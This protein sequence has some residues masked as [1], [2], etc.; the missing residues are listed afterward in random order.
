M[1]KDTAFP[2]PY[3]VYKSKYRS[4]VGQHV[5]VV[6]EKR[7]DFKCSMCNYAAGVRKVLSQHVKSV[8]EHIKDHVCEKCDYKS[9]DRANILRHM[10]RV[11][12]NIREHECSKCDMTFSRSQDL[13][14]HIKTHDRVKKTVS[15]NTPESIPDKRGHITETI[16][17]I[18]GFKSS[19]VSELARHVMEQCAATE[20]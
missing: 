3:C 5:R 4:N 17:Q 7:R 16:C 20:N 13:L 15:K 8:H 14:R 6:H 19:K 1:P 11:H 10:K 18:C 2:C 12:E 9:S